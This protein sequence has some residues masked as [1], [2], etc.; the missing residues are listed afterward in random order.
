MQPLRPRRTATSSKPKAPTRPRAPW[1]PRAVKSSRDSASSTPSKRSS[2]KHQHAKVL[3]VRGVKQITPNAPITTQAA[4]SV[5]DNF[6][7]GS[8]ANND[9]THRWYGD[10]VETND[11]NS[12][13]DGK[14]T[15]GW[16]DKRRQAPHHR[17]AMAPST[18]APP[19]PRARPASRS[20]SRARAAV[21]SAGEYVS[22]QAS[23]NGGVA[24][25]RSRP[26]L[27][28]RQRHR[29]HRAELQHHRVIAAAIPRSASSRR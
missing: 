15:I 28:R 20:S 27:G 3:A 22:V 17:L 18:V 16:T 2:P 5:R 23:A 10:W 29:L 25:D 4:A 24:L 19:R 6:E 1:P 11:N 8:F 26:H 9:G 13:Y 7:T 14:V 12:P 21:S